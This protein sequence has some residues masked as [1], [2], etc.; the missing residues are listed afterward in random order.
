M[1]KTKDSFFL[2]T[3]FVS[4]ILSFALL[5]SGTVLAE[6]LTPEGIMERVDENEHIEAARMESEMIIQDRDREMIKEMIV[7]IES[8]NR[9]SNSLTEFVN[10]RDRGTK[11]LKL[12]DD[13]WMYF[14]DAEDLVSISGHMM[15]EGMMGS[16]F[17]Y[18]DALESEQLTDLYEFE[19]V[20]EEKVNDRDAYVLSAV[21]REGEEVSYYERKL[22]VDRERFVI[23]RE[24]YFS[25]GGRLLKVLEVEEVQQFT[26][27]RWFPVKSVMN[28][29]L[30]EDSQTVHKIH[31]ID[32]DYEIPADLITL[33]AL[34]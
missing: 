34:Q 5:M 29:K 22:W 9:R 30:K 25:T 33:D 27:G 19:L 13:L 4:I 3:L 1:S 14:S 12:G 2:L 32:F 17:S 23:L 16:D 7:Y 8:D 26:D 24:E 31:E 28:D 20:G 10:P 6:Q 21:A 18:E 11:Y 15:R